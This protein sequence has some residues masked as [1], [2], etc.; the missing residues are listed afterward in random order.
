[1]AEQI[2]IVSKNIILVFLGTFILLGLIGNIF[3]FLVFSS[4]SIRKHS[5][6]NYFRAIA[7]CDLMILCNG[8]FHF[9]YNLIEFNLDVVNDFFCRIKSFIF[10]SF[11]AISPWLMVIV[12]VDR[13]LNIRYPKRFMFLHNTRYQIG[14]ILAVSIY[15]FL[16]YSFMAWNVEL[17]T[18]KCN[19]FA[20]LQHE[21]F[22]ILD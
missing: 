22:S 1:M 11:G 12:S 13:L 9:L 15:N 16:L 18:T 8:I 3:T 14:L 5:I 7:I 19:E 10:Y 6:S 21:D 2:V 4:S 20:F 17:K